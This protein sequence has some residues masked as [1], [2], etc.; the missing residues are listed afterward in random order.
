MV[1][2]V[3]MNAVT[4]TSLVLVLWRL[5]IYSAPLWRVGSGFALFSA[6]KHRVGDGFFV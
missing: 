4:E 6:P 2:I 1:S 5:A 3:V